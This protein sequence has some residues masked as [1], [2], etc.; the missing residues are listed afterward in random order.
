LLPLPFLLDQ[1][2]VEDGD[3]LLPFDRHPAPGEANDK[4]RLH[5]P[6]QASP[7]EPLVQ[8]EAAIDGDRRQPFDLPG[9]AF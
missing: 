2:A 8:P 9:P 1:D 7:G 5:R 6:T 3:Q 4:Q